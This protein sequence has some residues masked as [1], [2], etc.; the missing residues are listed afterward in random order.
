MAPFYVRRDMHNEFMTPHAD[1]PRLDRWLIYLIGCAVFVGILYFGLH[2][3][4]G[5]SAM[6][7]IVTAVP[8]GIIG[9]F[10]FAKIME[11]TP[12]PPGFWDDSG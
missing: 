3:L 8:T 6:V 5:I 10:I 1:E 12:T 4:I 11:D 2:R 7:S 9:L